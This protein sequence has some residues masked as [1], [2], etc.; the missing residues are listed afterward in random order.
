MF[1]RGF[2]FFG[3]GGG[4][5][6]VVCLFLFCFF[7]ARLVKCKRVNIWILEIV[8]ARAYLV[9]VSDRASLF[10]SRK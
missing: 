8:I 10:T 9:L 4:W 2:F 3:G 1:Y 7:A 5:F 6:L